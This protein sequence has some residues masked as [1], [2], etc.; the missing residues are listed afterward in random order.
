MV[1]ALIDRRVSDEAERML[2]LQGFNTVRLP[3]CPTL[4]EAICSHPDTL[5]FKYKNE[6]ITAAEYCEYAAYVFGDLRQLHPTLKI[7][8][9]DC[10]HGSK[11]PEDCRYNALYAG[12]RVFANTDNLCDTVKSTLQRESVAICRVRQ[13]YPACATAVIG[14]ILITSDEG[15]CRAF[16]AQGLDCRLIEAGSISLPP[17]EYGF[18]GGACGVFGKKVY[19]FG[20]YRLH[21]SH[22]VIEEAMKD[23]GYEPICLCQGGLEDMGG[24]LFIDC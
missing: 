24:I 13:G 21:P 9:A 14:D 22:S 15:L 7:T 8:F 19:F 16:G 18:I 20:D 6:I 5:I 12:G 1:S 11:Y 10:G 4:P 17:Y 23:G 3:S 2:M